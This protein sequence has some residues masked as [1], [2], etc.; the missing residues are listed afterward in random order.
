MKA[1]NL[2]VRGGEKK[3]TEEEESSLCLLFMPSSLS[4]QKVLRSIFKYLIIIVKISLKMF[5]E[6][7]PKQV[8]GVVCFLPVITTRERK[9]V[10]SSASCKRRK[11]STGSNTKRNYPK[12]FFEKR[13]V[14]LLLLLHH[15]GLHFDEVS[16]EYAIMQVT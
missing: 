9:S 12:Q 6:A 4:W 7:I 8:F 5:H 1:R 2:C 14:I 11:T 15:L 3:K 16:Y 10:E 13:K